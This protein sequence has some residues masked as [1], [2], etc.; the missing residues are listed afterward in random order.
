MMIIVENGIKFLNICEI[1]GGIFFGILIV[2]LC[3]I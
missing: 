2:I 3:F 1:F